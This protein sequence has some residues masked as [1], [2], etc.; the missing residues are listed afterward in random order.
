MS[1]HMTKHL[2]QASLNSLMNVL[3][4]CQTPYKSRAVLSVFYALSTWQTRT[5]ATSLEWMVT[6]WQ[7]WADACHLLFKTFV[8]LELNSRLGMELE[9]HHWRVWVCWTCRWLMPKLHWCHHMQQQASMQGR[10][11]LC[12]L[13]PVF[14]DIKQERNERRTTPSHKVQILMNRSVIK[15]RIFLLGSVKC[16]LHTAPYSHWNLLLLCLCIDAL[17]QCQVDYPAMVHFCLI[18]LAI[19]T[20]TASVIL[21]THNPWCETCVKDTFWSMV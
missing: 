12:P 16:W 4:R 13:F 8:P 17:Y 20:L 10:I 11:S 5:M 18:S 19:L 9:E 14:F 6:S 2:H 7:Q 1:C 21:K 15:E 3:L